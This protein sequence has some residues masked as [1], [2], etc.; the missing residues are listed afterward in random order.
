MAGMNISDMDLFLSDQGASDTE[1]TEL[2]AL[3]GFRVGKTP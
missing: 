1:Q 2:L 3:T